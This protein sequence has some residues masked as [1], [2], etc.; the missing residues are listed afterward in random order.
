MTV[1][2]ARHIAVLLSAPS[3]GGAERAMVGVANHLAERGHRVDMVLG[4]VEGPYLSAISERIRIVDLKSPRIRGLL[5]P[6][7]RY[8]RT[9]RPDVLLSALTAPSLVACLGK[10]L[11]RWPTRLVLSVQN[12]PV[13]SA[14]PNGKLMQRFLPHLVRAL[15]SRADRLI[16][17]SR[18]VA[19]AAA[20]LTRRPR[21]EVPVIHNPV[22]TPEFFA[23]LAE[24]PDHP[25]IANRTAPVLLAAGRLTTQKDYPTLFEA[26]ARVRR[27]RPARLVVLGQGPDEAELKALVERLGVAEDVH[28]AGFVSNPYAWMKR[29]DLF[30]LSSRWEGFA[31]VVAEALACG[32]PVVSTDCPSG[33]AEILADGGFG[34]LAPVGDPE[35]LAAQ[36][37]AAL[38][39]TH[40]RAALEARGRSFSLDALAPRYAQVLE[41]A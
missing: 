14:D 39:E 30:V 34:R 18:G 38:D 41:A 1:E 37:L 15:Y 23:K 13:A 21:D 11:H 26:F 17:I 25:W 33:P 8:V 2:H 16:G 36:I 28:F 27:T 32:A 20:D 24:E 7:D 3:G 19:E 10:T 6:L 40:D 31:N 35:A 12:H 4:R 9:E 22:I 29:C 5:G